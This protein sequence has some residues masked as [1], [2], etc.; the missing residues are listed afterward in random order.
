MGTGASI[1][2]SPIAGGKSGRFLKN[3]RKR[4]NVQALDL[5]FLRSAQ[6]FLCAGKVMAVLFVLL[7]SGYFLRS[8]SWGM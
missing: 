8:L 7:S 3:D 2:G 5:V 4:S 1:H 6:L